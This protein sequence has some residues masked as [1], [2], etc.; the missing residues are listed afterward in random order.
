[1]PNQSAKPLVTTISNL[2]AERIG[3]MPGKALQ[4]AIE[5][6]GG[7]D[8]GAL[9]RALENSDDSSPTWQ[10]IMRAL[11]IGETYFFRQQSQ[12]NWLKQTVLPDLFKRHPTSISLW[13][14]G[15]ATGEEVYSIAMTLHEN[16]SPTQRHA[17]HLI[18]SD[19]NRAALDMARRGVY[20]DW[21]FRHTDT[22][23]QEHYFD[24][25]ESGAQI[26]MKL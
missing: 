11:M 1:M 2:V 25:V 7:D 13:S 22:A 8:L 24:R 14:A 12:L 4:D 9:L 10:A 23:L 26:K 5:E 16:T 17:I 18:G 3:L 6:V 15:C 21:S 20:R 19:I